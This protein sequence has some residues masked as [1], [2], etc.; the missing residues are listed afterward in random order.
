M[1]WLIYTSKLNKST[2]MKE[3]FEKE[4]CSIF[5]FKK[6]DIIIRLKSVDITKTEYN[7]N[8]GIPVKTKTGIDNSFRERPIEFIC[9]ENNLI[10]LRN[11][12]DQQVYSAQLNEFSED[13]ALFTVPEGLAFE[14]C[15]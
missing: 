9:V 13:W 11:P 2:N 5:C 8:L 10:Y 14:D 12:R 7:D 15:I 3:L 1:K 6:N 4:G